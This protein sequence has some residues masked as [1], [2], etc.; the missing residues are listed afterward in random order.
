MEMMESHLAYY[1][2]L[3]TSP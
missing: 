1:F 3:H 2:L